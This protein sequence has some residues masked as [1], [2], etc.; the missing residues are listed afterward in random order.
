M[1]ASWW[2]L[3]EAEEGGCIV[4]ILHPLLAVFAIIVILFAKR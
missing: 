1:I 2:C 3:I 4:L